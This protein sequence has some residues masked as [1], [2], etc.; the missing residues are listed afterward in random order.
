MATA[1]RLIAC[2]LPS[3]LMAQ[4]PARTQLTV[5]AGLPSVSIDGRPFFT[6]SGVALV[7]APDARYSFAFGIARSIPG[8]ALELR[9]EYLYSRAVST[10]G[11]VREGDTGI[12]G[13]MALRDECLGVAASLD[14][15][16][17]PTWRLTP[18]LVTGLGFYRSRLGTNPDPDSTTVTETYQIDLL[19]ANIGGG[20]L[21]RLR[22]L[23]AFFEI[24]Q[25]IYLSTD[26]HGS[27]YMP[28]VLG[29]RY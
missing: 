29:L 17:L 26:P 3:V 24:R 11:F 13:T 5:S 18:Y 14:W 15:L 1:H 2:L 12:S 21:L 27:S 10:G 22:R 25:Q 23:S 8:S 28:I 20:L 7:G 9:A 4:A 19:G 16:A 6:R